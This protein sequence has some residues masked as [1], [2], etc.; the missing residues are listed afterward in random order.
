MCGIW[1]VFGFGNIAECGIEHALK[2]RHRGPDFTRIESIPY[3][4]QCHLVFHRLSIIDSGEDSFSEQPMRL[5]QYPH[6]R[7][8]YNGEIYNY[9]ELFEKYA[10]ISETR[11]DGEVIIHLYMKFGIKKTLQLLDGVFAIIIFDSELN[12]ISFGR[13]TFGVRPLFKVESLSGQLGLSSEAKALMYLVKTKERVLKIMP[14]TP[15][16]FSQYSVTSEGTSKLIRNERF[17]DVDTPQEFDIPVL[18][19]DNIKDNIYNLLQDAVRKRLMSERKIGCLLSGGLDSSLVTSL[20]V[21]LGKDD[22]NN[23]PIET[24]SIGLKDS[25]DLFYA[26]KVASMLHTK[27]H[28]VVYT[29]ADIYNYLADTVY[30]METFDPANIRGGIVFYLLIKYIK[31]NTDCVVLFSGEGA[32]E[33]TQGY[34][35]FKEKPNA[36][37]CL[38]ESKLLLRDLYLFAGLRPDRCVSAFG[39]EL[40]LPFLDKAFCSYYLSLP[41]ELITQQ[42]GVE[43]YLLR[44]SFA[45]KLE[46]FLPNDVLWRGKEALT[47]GC[48]KKDNTLLG[49]ME[50]LA[51]PVVSNEEFT[52]AAD[53]FPFN[54]PRDYQSYW[55][56]KLFESYFPSQAQL[57]P[58]CWDDKGF[59]KRLLLKKT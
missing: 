54:T 15:G 8:I 34:K 25:P 49:T 35:H 19:N 1:A 43:K 44:K 33:L 17:T 39:L 23:N 16:F 21:K 29:E 51:R 55:Y 37:E 4:N 10:F 30:T 58:Y 45:G 32:D 59:G 46:E 14:Y 36:E 2:I 24:F 6:V 50:K 13:D 18:L 9:K 52:Y 40:R 28:E 5:R 57:T 11:N 47:E 41:K 3:Y 27:H 56:R 12:K 48:S 53:T 26:R 7:M 42:L 20:L 31:E 38:A 22:N